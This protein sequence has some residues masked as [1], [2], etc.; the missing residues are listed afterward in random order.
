MTDQK[1]VEQAAPAAAPASEAPAAAQ[2]AAESPKPK[3]APGLFQGFTLGSTLKQ[4]PTG[5]AMANVKQSPM[6]YEQRVKDSSKNQSLSA[7]Q[8]EQLKSKK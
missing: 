7:E 6:D 5:N 3:L 2:P 1:P 8:L 4:G